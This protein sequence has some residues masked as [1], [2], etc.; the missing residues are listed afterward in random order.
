MQL[1]SERSKSEQRSKP[2]TE[3]ETLKA[4]N[5]MMVRIQA[6][7][8]EKKA[9]QQS[10]QAAAGIRGLPAG[11]DPAEEGRIIKAHHTAFNHHMFSNKEGSYAEVAADQ[12]SKSP[13]RE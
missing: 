4:L 6:H 13:T 3:P 1:T 2:D 12:G 5:Q 7:N 8:L 9:K 10:G 11:Y